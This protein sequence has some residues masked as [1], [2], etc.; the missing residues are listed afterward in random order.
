MEASC[1]HSRP[2]LITTEM[3]RGRAMALSDSSH[4]WKE[5]KPERSRFFLDVH[6]EGEL[7]ASGNLKG[8]LSAVSAGYPAQRVR[9]QKATG[10]P[11]KEMISSIFFDAYTH[12]TI[13]DEIV[14]IQPEYPDSTLLEANFEIPDYA[15]S[16]DRTSTRRN[17]SPVAISYA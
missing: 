16:L 15:I 6:I 11:D 4:T 7:D 8:R 17:S 5:I 9:R 14:K 13:S 3:Y 2:A 10:V 1:N 12:T